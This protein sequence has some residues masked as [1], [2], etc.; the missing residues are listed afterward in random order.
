MPD[1]AFVYFSLNNTFELTGYDVYMIGEF[2]FGELLPEYKMT[3]NPEKGAYELNTLLKQGYYNYMYV[4]TP[5][6]GTKGSTEF[7]ED[8]YQ[9][10]ENDYSIFVYVRE[11]GDVA[12][13]LSG[14]TIINSIN[15]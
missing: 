15:K 8:N 4:T 6:G 13:R 1:Y 10:T 3:F 11:S 14:T 9:F 12:L 2:S 7:I 5:A